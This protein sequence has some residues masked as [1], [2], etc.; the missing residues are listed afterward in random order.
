MG[1]RTDICPKDPCYIVQSLMVTINI[2]IA[3]A[4]DVNPIKLE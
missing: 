3:F 1:N 4:L 2:E